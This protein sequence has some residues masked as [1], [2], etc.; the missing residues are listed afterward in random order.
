MYHYTVAIY[1]TQDAFTY[2]GLFDEQMQDILQEKAF[3]N[4]IHNGETLFF[5]QK[6]GFYVMDVVHCDKTGKTYLIVIPR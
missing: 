5:N 1:Q 3:K 2:E 4:P 6:H